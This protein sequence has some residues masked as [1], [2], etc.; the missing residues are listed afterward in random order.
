MDFMEPIAIF[1]TGVLTRGVIDALM[2]IAPFRQTIVNIILIRVHPAAGCNDL[3]DHGLDRHLLHIGQ[4]ADD[5][6]AI[7]LDQTQHWR[8]LVR[9]RPAPPFSF[10][11]SPTPFSTFLSYN[12][13]TAFVPGDEIHFV[14]FD[15]APQLGR[16]FLT[17]MPSC[18]WVVIIWA[19]PTDRSSSAA[20]C[21]LDKF[22][23]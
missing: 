12:V 22:K 7:T 10:Q 14:G 23:P 2:L 3:R 8:L 16:L 15:L 19:S 13:W 17:T 1:I 4:H 21:S 20:I 11:P 5:Y 9:Q 6:I 18:N